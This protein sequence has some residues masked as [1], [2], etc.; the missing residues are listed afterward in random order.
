MRRAS[1]GARMPIC[2]GMTASG[3]SILAALCAARLGA[4]HYDTDRVRNELD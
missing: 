1:E 4:P 3:K 2:F